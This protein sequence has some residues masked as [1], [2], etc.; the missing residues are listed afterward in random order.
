MTDQPNNLLPPACPGCGGPL[1]NAPA[2]S[3]RDSLTY[4]CALCREYEAL[5]L[6]LRQPDYWVDHDHPAAA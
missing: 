6:H 1:P 3:Q 2:V 4:I 5:I